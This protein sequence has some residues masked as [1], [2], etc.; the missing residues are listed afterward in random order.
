MWLPW[1][2]KAKPMHQ[3]V[4]DPDGFEFDPTGL[5]SDP[6]HPNAMRCRCGRPR[7]LRRL[8]SLTGPDRVLLYCPS[9]DQIAP[10]QPR[11]PHDP[12]TKETP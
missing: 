9:C 12:T 5:H 10:M 1:R 6:S 4:P 2:R 3:P 8:V 7:V 11:R